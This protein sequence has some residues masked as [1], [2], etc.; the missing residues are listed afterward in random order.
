MGVLVTGP[1]ATFFGSPIGV[2]AVIAFLIAFVLLV[3]AFVF[4]RN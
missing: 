4:F 1:V 2:I 3:A